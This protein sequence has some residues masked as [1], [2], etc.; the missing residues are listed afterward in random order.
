MTGTIY[1]KDAYDRISAFLSTYV[2][3][4]DTAD[5]TVP[6]DCVAFKRAIAFLLNNGVFA[7]MDDMKRACLRAQNIV[8]PD[9]L[10]P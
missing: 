6:K 7:G 1:T 10:F 2:Q 3:F 4:T 5:K 9:F 8:L